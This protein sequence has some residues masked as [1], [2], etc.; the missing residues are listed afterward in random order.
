MIDSLDI[1]NGFNNCL[2][3]VGPKL[4]NNL[5]SDI[6]PLSYVNYN[7]NSIVVPEV[8]CIQVREVNN[9]L[10]NSSPGPIIAKAC[11]DGFIEPITYLINESLTFGV[12]LYELK[13]ASV[14]PIFKSGDPSLLTN[15]RPIFVL[16]FFSKIFEKLFII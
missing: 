11:I 2:V 16:S 4:A 9:S 13:L 15:Y 8:S 10:N 12:F 14:V 1:A 3:S 7:I 5:K 6:D